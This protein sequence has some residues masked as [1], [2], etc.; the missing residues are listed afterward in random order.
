[1]LIEVSPYMYTYT[2]VL[3]DKNDSDVRFCLQVIEYLKSID[4]L[5]IY[6]IHM[7]GLIHK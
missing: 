6:P 7:I 1:M 2:T 5:S 3:Q 4:H